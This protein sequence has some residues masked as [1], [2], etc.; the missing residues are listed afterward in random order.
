MDSHVSADGSAGVTDFASALR[1]WR[2]SRG[3][4]QL[5]LS[6]E[7]GISQRHLSF[8]E[9]GRA[10]PGR[11]TV[12]KLG[13]VLDIPLRQRNAML[14]AAGFAPAYRERSLRDPELDAVMRALEFMLAQQSPY[15]AL[16]V[17]RLWNLTMINLPATRMLR[18]LLD[19]PPQAPIAQDGSINV[20]AMMLDAAGLRRYLVNWEAVGAD[21]LGW[22]QREAMADGPGSD[23]QRLVETLLALPGVAAGLARPAGADP[24]GPGLPLL[25]LALSK[26]GVQ[27]NLFTTITT[28]GTPH[29]VTLHGLRLESFFPADEASRQWFIALAQAADRGESDRSAKL[30]GNRVIPAT[31]IAK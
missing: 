17:D 6:L 10:H 19:L 2:R 14:L 24:D 21:M 15:P 26:H 30:A 9:T 18:W 29:D 23:A 16:V 8:M 27:L 7:S 25:P 4:S 22:V 5:R 28:L 1:H 20:L 31:R 12:L 3:F 11:E 13:I